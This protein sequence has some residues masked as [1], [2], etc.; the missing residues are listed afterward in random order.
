MTTRLKIVGMHCNACK[1]LIEDVA[2]EA[3]GV[4][5]CVVDVAAGTALITHDVSF[6]PADLI[7]EIGSLG[8]YKAEL[9]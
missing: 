6:A 2:M 4:T 7:R 9:V 5:D 1:L 8:D 3:A